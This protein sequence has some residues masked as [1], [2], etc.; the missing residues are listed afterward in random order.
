V[1][2]VWTGLAVNDVEAHVNYLSQFNELAARELAISL[3][4]AGDSLSAMPKH[5]RPG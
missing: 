1:N 5:R 3:F 2:V 4:T